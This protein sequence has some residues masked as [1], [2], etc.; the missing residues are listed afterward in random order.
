MLQRRLFQAITLGLA[1]FLLSGCVYLRLLKFKNQL[2]DFD[3]H[4]VVNEAE[5]FSLQFPDPVLR[6]EDFVF[7][8]E[9]EPTQVRTI[10]RNPRVEDWEWQ[11]EKKLETEDGAP[12]SIIFTTRFEEG[13]LTQIEFDPKLLQAIPEDF[14]VELFRSLGQA[15]INKLRRS[16]TA[17]MSRDSQE[18]IDFPSMSEISVVMGEPTTQRKE[19]RQGFWH[20]VFNFYNPANRDLSGQF[21]I[22]FTTDSENLEDEIAGLEL[23]GKAR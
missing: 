21:A 16:A 10:T 18:Q 8:T 3:E 4:V 22:V 17:A 20:Y 13:M 5:P 6:D 12:F 23:T 14:I 7:V 2:H 15:K 9:S 1:L 19:D 11:F